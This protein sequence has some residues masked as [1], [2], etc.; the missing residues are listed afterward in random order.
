MS[1]KLG[2]PVR[3][4]VARAAAKL[5]REEQ[6][7]LVIKTSP[8]VLAALKIRAAQKGV[9]MRVYVLGLLAADGIEAASV[10]LDPTGPRRP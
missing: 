7:R 3:P 2:R 9:P 8:A 4:S 6:A 5:E 10:D 1:T